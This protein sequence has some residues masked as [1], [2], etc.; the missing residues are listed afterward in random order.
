MD[1]PGKTHRQH[2]GR[3]KGQKDKQ[4]STK[5]AHNTKDRVKRTPLKLEGNSGS[6]EV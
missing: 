6:T 5:H 4:R 1:N 2:N 3:E